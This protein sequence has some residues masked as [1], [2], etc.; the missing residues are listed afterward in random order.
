MP[1]VRRG[2]GCDGVRHRS[3]GLDGVWFVW[4]RSLSPAVADSRVVQDQLK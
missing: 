3:T 1:G 2:I 4:L